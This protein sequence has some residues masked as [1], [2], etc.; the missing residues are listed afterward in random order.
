MSRG[1]HASITTKGRANQVALIRVCDVTF[2]PGEVETAPISVGGQQ[3]AEMDLGPNGRKLVVEAVLAA[4][5]PFTAGAAA[6]TK[7]RPAPTATQ[8]VDTE[9]PEE[10]DSTGDGA[11]LRLSLSAEDRAACRAWGKRNWRRIGL[12]EEPANRGQISR[13][14]AEEW[15]RAGRPDPRG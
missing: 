1:E 11:D 15:D 9:D 12:E 7:P 13:Q 14:L 5:E 8:P 6:A 4:L 2:E 10:V 3:I